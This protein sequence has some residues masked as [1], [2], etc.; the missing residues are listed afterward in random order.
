M[1]AFEKNSLK[2][3]FSFEK[4]GTNLRITL[5]ATNSSNLPFNDFIFQAAVPKVS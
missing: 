4:N 1:I 2:I 5:N 3:E